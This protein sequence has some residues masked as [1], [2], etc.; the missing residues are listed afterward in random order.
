MEPRSFEVGALIYIYR[1]TKQGKSKKP[2]AAS[3][4]PAVVIG[5]ERQ[6]YWAAR[7]G[8]CL[9]VAPE[10]AREARHEEVKEMFRFKAAMKEL[11]QVIPE[12]DDESYESVDDSAAPGNIEVEVGEEQVDQTHRLGDRWA[13]VANREEL[14]RTYARRTKLLHDVPE[15]S[16]ELA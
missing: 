12:P 15:A 3:I 6:N 9:L 5:R 8:R 2:T 4:G 16:S 14:I 11:Q 10:H 7:G 1:E 13:E